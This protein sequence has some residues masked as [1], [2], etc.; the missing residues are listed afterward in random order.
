MRTVQIKNQRYEE[1][2]QVKRAECLPVEGGS[3]SS[4]A[5][6]EG[7]NSSETIRKLDLCYDLELLGIKGR[8]KYLLL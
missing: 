3:N 8:R 4:N 5:E 2:Q 6:Q 1:Q 7:E